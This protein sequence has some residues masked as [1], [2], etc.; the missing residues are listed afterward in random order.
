MARSQA[1]A[2]VR[3]YVRVSVD[4]PLHP[5][6]AD[7][8]NP[9][10]GWAY[11]VSLCYCGQS[12]TDGLFRLS[13]VSRLAGVDSGIC[14]LLV[15]QGLWHAR[16]HECDRC[17]Q[18]RE[19]YAV[20]HDYLSH[21]RSS[22]EVQELSAKRRDAGR[23]GARARWS[24]AEAPA[25]I[26]SAM[27]KPMASAI[28]DGGDQCPQPERPNGGECDDSTLFEIAKPMASAMANGWQDDGRGE[29][30]REEKNKSFTRRSATQQTPSTAAIVAAYMDGA[31]EA[32]RDRPAGGLPARVGR[33]AKQL[34]GE[35]IPVE[36]L[37]E[38]A[39][40]MGRAGWNDLATQLQR[41]SGEQKPA[42]AYRA[43]QEKRTPT[44]ERDISKFLKAL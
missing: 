33:Q 38:A 19:G 18:P 23:R 21:Q 28:D 12:M 27:A 40:Q 15:D 2:D 43:Y 34:L 30:R 5:K 26:A 44:G 13:T 7:L 35:G 8:D 6:L 9:A 3:P 25:P 36:K 42:T 29:E 16:G 1:P 4:L 39:K 41:M 37:T 11:V 22:D 24:H 20:V 17:V 10:A 14:S 31:A 32:G